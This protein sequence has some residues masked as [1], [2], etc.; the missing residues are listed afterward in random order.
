M[1]MSTTGFGVASSLGTQ[2]LDSPVNYVSPGQLSND[3]SYETSAGFADAGAEIQRRPTSMSERKQIPK[4]PAIILR[5]S[6]PKTRNFSAATATAR[7]CSF[8]RAELRDSLDTR[9]FRRHSGIS[10]A[11]PTTVEPRSATTAA[12]A[13]TTIT[14]SLQLPT[15]VTDHQPTAFRVFIRYP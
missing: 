3:N 9:H 12:A 1:C 2:A 7:A 4:S 13:T 10:L 5:S 15:I 6:G 8:P 11:I 14:S